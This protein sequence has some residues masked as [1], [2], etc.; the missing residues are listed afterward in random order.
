VVQL[1]R[2]P[3]GRWRFYI[4]RIVDHH[5]IAQIYGRLLVVTDRDYIYLP[6]QLAVQG[7]GKDTKLSGA[8]QDAT[9]A[10]KNNA[11]WVAYYSANEGLAI[12]NVPDSRTTSVQ[13]VTNVKTGAATRFTGINARSWTEFGGNLYFG[14]VDGTVNK[15]IGTQDIASAIKCISVTAP[16][17]LARA[18]EG[19]VTAYRSRITSN[20]T[21]TITSALRFDFEDLDVKQTQ[22]I[23]AP[24]GGV[25]PLDWPFDWPDAT[26]DPSRTEWFK[27]TGRGTFVQLYLEA[28]IKNTTDSWF[29]NEFI[30]ERGGILM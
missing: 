19:L 11:G 14:G 21:F 3:R 20:G 28:S 23:P 22:S 4:G 8:A 15:Y 27:G 5:A 18:A 30:V 24:G 1:S 12:I 26:L 29:G 25:L 2:S 13:H 9:K 6:D 17:R 10:Y 16:S 7:G